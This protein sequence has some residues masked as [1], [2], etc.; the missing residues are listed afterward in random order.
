MGESKELRGSESEFK[1]GEV[2]YKYISLDN[3][4]KKQG[5]DLGRLPITIKILMENVARKSRN[6]YK[7]V[8]KLAN[9]KSHAGKHSIPYYPARILMQDFTGVPAIVDLAA[10]R[11]SAA[12]HGVDVK[13][14][15]P[16]CAVDLVIDHSVSVDYYGNADALEKNIKVEMKRNKERYQ[17]LKWG[18]KAFNNFRVVP[19]GNGIC[20][21]V[22]LEYL[23]SC[24]CE[25][26]CEEKP[27]LFPDTLVGTDSHT[28]MINALG[29]LGWGVG[30]IEAEAIM[31]GQPL[32]LIIPNVV[33]VKLS[34]CLQ[35]G[36]TATDLVL[37]VAERLR[38]HGVVGKFVEFYGEGVTQLSLSERATIS[39]MS[40]EFGS[41]CAFFPIDH[42]S[43]RYLRTTARD[44]AHVDKVAKY[45]LEQG[46]WH[47][48]D[49]ESSIFSSHIE[50][51]LSGIMPCVAGPKRPQDKVLLP[52]LALATEKAII[53]QPQTVD[54]GLKSQVSGQG[55]TLSHGD[56]V[57][58][59]I[60]SCTN[61]SN[62]AV[63][64]TAALL[65]K[66]ALE[67]GLSIKPWVKASFA[68]GS[69]VVV[70]YLKKLDLLKP[71]EAMGFYLVGF[72]CTTC[73]GNSGPLK[74]EISQC[75]TE[76]HLKVSAVLSGNRNFEGRIHPEVA[77]NWLASPPLV[78]A[79]AIAGTTKVDL[80]RTVLGKNTEGRSIHLTDIWPE[81]DQ[82]EAMQRQITTTMYQEQ[83]Q[84]I[85]RGNQ[86]WDELD[87]GGGETYDWQTGST[88]I[89]KPDFFSA[90][91]SSTRPQDINRAY[92]LAL[93]GDSIT[94]DHISPAGFIPASTPAGK[95]LKQKQV[96]QKDFNSYGSRRGNHHI[97]VRGTFA[98][99][100]LKNQCVNNLLGGFTT[101]WPTQEIMPIYD[102]CQKYKLENQDLVVIAGKEYGTGS[103][104]DWA[105]KG[106]MMLG[107]KVVIA[108]S[109]ERIH[110]SNLIGMGVLPCVLA[111]VSLSQL[112]LVGCERISVHGIEDMSTVN[113][114]LQMKIERS[115]GT[116]AQVDLRSRLDTQREFDYYQSSGVLPYV[117]KEIMMSKSE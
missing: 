91:S 92:I 3:I 61:T 10:M 5:F 1:C 94:T 30:G 76:N 46:L 101:H 59:A 83:Y 21:Q 50:V 93:L 53:D 47:R 25:E 28:T 48:S 97:M 105:A 32:D 68:P 52:A 67:A 115:D 100:K 89:Q 51:D 113:A 37:T 78:I 117:L 108:E 36:V 99:I 98:N 49:L 62:P 75:I 116:V 90:A 73:I 64:I 43:L 31:L 86:H 27:L 19:P 45:C 85:F 41:T 20:H 54:M 39:N 109:F 87:A 63:L 71:L 16:L 12:I 77:M 55:Y 84:D 106:T 33:G 88:Y 107:V 6:G 111:G 110:R 26:E 57:I 114:I 11:D 102:A 72:G 24:V 60:T 18:Q 35:T 13:K 17:F 58:A 56:V 96:D 81:Q 34:G 74:K 112:K 7:E 104:R 29:V 42:E 44:S 9:W 95:Y 80:S 69:K 22:N 40:P 65:A 66:K 103:S 23:A 79:F 15:N 8:K 82:V 2:S 70:D 38:K 4:S 14:V